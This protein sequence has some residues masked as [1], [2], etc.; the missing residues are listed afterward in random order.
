MEGLW[1]RFFNKIDLRFGE[2]IVILQQKSG[3]ESALEVTD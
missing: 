2:K 1:E 3:A